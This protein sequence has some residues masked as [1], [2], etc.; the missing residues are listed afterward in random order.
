MVLFNPRSNCGLAHAEAK[1]D[2]LRREPK[3]APCD[4]DDDRE[5]SFMNSTIFGFLKCGSGES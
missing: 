5:H 1:G 4:P 2:E 3:R